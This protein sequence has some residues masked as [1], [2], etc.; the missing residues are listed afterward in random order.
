MIWKKLKYTQYIQLALQYTVSFA[1][2]LILKDTVH[3]QANHLRNCV[4]ILKIKDSSH[5][6]KRVLIETKDGKRKE[7]NCDELYFDVIK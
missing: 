7:V 2:E 4:T 6:N 1:S 3:K 5:L